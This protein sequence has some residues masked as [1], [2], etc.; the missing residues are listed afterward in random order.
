MLN[1]L[2]SQTAAGQA[3]EAHRHAYNAAFEELGLTWYWDAAT[4]ARL[5]AHGRDGVRVYLET[6]QSHLLR[7]Y[8]AEFLVDA[9]ETTQTR[10][11]ASMSQRTT[12]AA[13]GWTGEPHM[14]PAARHNASSA[15]PALRLVTSALT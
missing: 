5:Q 15:A 4:Y 8:E 10:C 12:Q 7:A 1:A 3:A 2:L 14:S 6:E 9:I 13:Y 11:Y